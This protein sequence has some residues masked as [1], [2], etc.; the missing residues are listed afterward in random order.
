MTATATDA[1]H[2]VKDPIAALDAAKESFTAR[3]PSHDPAGEAS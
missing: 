3:P 2:A 1:R